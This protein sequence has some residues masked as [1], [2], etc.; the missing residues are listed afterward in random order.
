MDLSLDSVEQE[1][2]NIIDLL[3]GDVKWVGTFFKGPTNLPVL[4]QV[5]EKSFSLDRRAK[6][7]IATEPVWVRYITFLS[8]DIKKFK[9]S[10]GFSYVNLKG[11]SVSKKLSLGENNSYVWINDV[12]VS[13]EIQS[14]AKLFKADLKKVSVCGFDLQELAKVSENSI[15]A[16]DLKAGIDKKL[17]EAKD[18]VEGLQNKI[19]SMEQEELELSERIDASR[20][21]FERISTSV[22]EVEAELESVNSELAASQA[23][24][25]AFRTQ[26]TNAQNNIEQ[27]KQAVA[28]LNRKIAEERAELEKLTSDRSLISDEYRD[29]VKEGR[30][31]SFWYLLFS[32]LPALVIILAVQQVYDSSEALLNRQFSSFSEVFSAFIQR[33]PFTLVLAGAVYYSWVLASGLL[34]RVFKIHNDRLTL[35]RLLVIAKDTV[36]SSAQG[37]N[38]DD[39]V[40]LRERVV[41]KIE[42][43]KSHLARD[44]SPDFEYKGVLP[45]NDEQSGPT[46]DSQK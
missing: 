42:L 16:F 24:L 5:A 6:R 10:V 39:E 29:Y 1:F 15:R 32:V 40:K 19:S 43:L 18:E 28:G 21:E 31:Q 36:Y 44:L 17:K 25:D 27:L 46:T 4:E 20:V 7:F 13:F 3:P 38:I 12:V 23:R 33:I 2:N 35:A 22:R 37:L 26:E 9:D 11:E 14:T 8:D 34:G 41:L 30:S 45:K